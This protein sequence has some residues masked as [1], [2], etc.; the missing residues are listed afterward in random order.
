M[1]KSWTCTERVNTMEVQC[2]SLLEAPSI[3]VKDRLKES[4]KKRRKPS[5]KQT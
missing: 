5:G 3:P 1:A 2:S 4:R